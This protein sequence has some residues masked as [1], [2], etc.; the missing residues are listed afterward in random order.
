[1]VRS[2]SGNSH[3][4]GQDFN[5]RLMK[6]FIDEFK[7]KYKKDVS[8]D[9]GVLSS[10]QA[11][12]ERAKRCLSS[13]NQASIAIDS[14]Y[15]GIDFYSSISRA[16]FEELNEDLFEATIDLVDKTICDANMLMNDVDEVVLVGGSTRIP[17][18]RNL[19]QE[20]FDGKELS[21]TINPDEA[22]AHG[23]AIRAAILSGD[24]S[25]AIQGLALYDVAPFT[26]GIWSWGSSSMNGI[27]QRNTIVPIQVTK[28]YKTSEDNQKT[29][30]PIRVYEIDG[31]D[32][33]RDSK[34]LGYFQLEGFPTTPKGS[35]F[36]VTFNIQEVI[37]FSLL[38]TYI[39]FHLCQDHFL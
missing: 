20:F 36:E 34:R 18:I 13:T 22:V 17:K 3:L 21:K 24:S 25:E 4:G 15:D 10:L 31:P 7:K 8:N 32:V 1:V 38:A 30:S 16:R 6:H 23:A 14:F 2:T 37:I 12:C 11:A 26:I 28:S 19:L 9:K 27:I 35:K 29:F 39:R 33:S 5:I